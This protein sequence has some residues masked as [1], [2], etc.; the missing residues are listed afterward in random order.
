MSS[1]LSFSSSLSLS[2]GISCCSSWRI[3]SNS[4]TMS[5]RDI[6]LRSLFTALAATDAVKNRENDFHIRSL[7]TIL[8]KSERSLFILKK[9]KVNVHLKP[10][11]RKANVHFSYSR[12]VNVHFSYPRKV[13]V[14]F[15]YP[16]KVNV[17]LK[18]YSRKVNVHFSYSRKEK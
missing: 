18:P 7:K 3:P 4:I 15:S 17:H 2:F 8:K 6:N 12:K 11:S 1:S 9:R 5:F 16:R 13:N 10:Y 14:H